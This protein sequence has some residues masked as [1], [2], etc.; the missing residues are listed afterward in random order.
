M[1]HH[2][3]GELFP[4]EVRSFCKGLSRSFSCIL[5]VVTLKFFP[6]LQSSLTLYGTFYFFA[7]ILLLSVPIVYF[8]VPETKDLGLE[9]IQNYFTKQRTI[10]YV[11]L[12]ADKEKEQVCSSQSNVEKVETSIH[13][14]V[15]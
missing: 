5:L 13:K 7:A 2:F 3:S 1:T 8:T 11:E 15:L 4:S 14:S 12:P 6:V 9:Q 10:F